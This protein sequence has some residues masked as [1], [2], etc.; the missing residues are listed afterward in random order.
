MADTSPMV[1]QGLEHLHAKRI[2]HRDLKPQNIFVTRS[3]NVK[4]G[5]MGLCKFLDSVCP[6]RSPSPAP[7]GGW[8]GGGPADCS[9]PAQ[10]RYAHSLCGTPLYSPPEVI[11][12]VRPSRT[13]PT[14]GDCGRGI[15][16]QPIDVFCG[17]GL[18]C[19]LSRGIRGFRFS[20]WPRF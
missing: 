20:S 11:N 15:P 6:A 18:F 13:P 10:A 1:A 3:D 16:T 8:V 19:C 2:I 17:I 9:R 14:L 7:C 12:E 5:D 4:I